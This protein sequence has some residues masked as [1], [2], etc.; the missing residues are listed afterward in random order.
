MSTLSLPRYLDCNFFLV[1]LMWLDV[2]VWSFNFDIQLVGECNSFWT[3]FL[4]RIYL[5][6]PDPCLMLFISEVMFVCV[7]FFWGWFISGTAS[8]CLFLP[9]LDFICAFRLSYCILM[10]LLSVSVF[11]EGFEI[12][13]PPGQKSRTVSVW[14]LSGRPSNVGLR[15]TSCFF[16]G[17]LRVKFML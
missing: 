8:Q 7:F 14:H 9:I 5:Y 15:Q 4:W 10:M 6:F 12:K 1:C 16:L 11:S 3:T 13:T 2:I 17:C